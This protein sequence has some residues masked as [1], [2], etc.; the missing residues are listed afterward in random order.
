MFHFSFRRVFHPM[1]QKKSFSTILQ[2][3]SAHD[4]GFEIIAED[5]TRFAVIWSDGSL[6]TVIYFEQCVSYATM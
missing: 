2:I 1:I 5:G 6:Y 4:G 3:W